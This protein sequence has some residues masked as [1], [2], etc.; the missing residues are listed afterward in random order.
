MSEARIRSR[1]WSE[2][3]DERSPFLG[4]EVRLC[5]Y[6]YYGELLGQASWLDVLWLM[7]RGEA[8]DP[9][10]GRLFGELAVLLADPGPRDASVHAAMCGGIGGSRPAAVLM[11]ALAVGAGEAGGSS[12]LVRAM[13]ALSAIGTGRALDTVLAERASDDGIWPGFDRASGWCASGLRT[14]LGRL[15]RS[16]LARALGELERLL[17]TVDGR[18]GLTTVGIAAAAFCD[19]GVPARQAEGLFLLLRLPGALAHGDEQQG[20]SHR[21]FPFFG[22]AEETP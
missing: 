17:D 20:R 4:R 1:I 15:A 12:E 16:P 21:A 8:P 2:T 6:D 18:Q 3:P 22:L 5:G 9:D 13:D 19:L 7:L 14:A 11:A 10:Q